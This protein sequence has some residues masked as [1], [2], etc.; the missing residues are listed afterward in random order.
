MKT[1]SFFSLPPSSRAVS[2]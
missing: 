1:T 2:L